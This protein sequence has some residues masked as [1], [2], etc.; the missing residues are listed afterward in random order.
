[1]DTL[2]L[3]EDPTQAQV[4]LRDRGLIAH[5][6]PLAIAANPDSSVAI[7]SAEIFAEL[8]A[9]D[10][11][12]GGDYGSIAVYAHDHIRD[13]H[14]FVAELAAPAGGDGFLLGRN[15]AERS[16]RDIVFGE[17]AQGK[18]GIAAEAGVFGLALH[19]DNLTDNLLL[20]GL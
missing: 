11:G 13:V 4:L 12:T 6:L 10:L 2:A 5:G 19:V 18:I 1:M 15:L 14:G 20:W 17:D 7:G 16:D 8:V 9:S 3:S